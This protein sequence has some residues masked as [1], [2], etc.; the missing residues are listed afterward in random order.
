MSIA[1]GCYIALSGGLFFAPV[2]LKDLL[3]AAF[4]IISSA[5]L[6]RR[7]PFISGDE[8]IMKAALE[9]RPALKRQRYGLSIATFVRSMHDGPIVRPVIFRSFCADASTS[10]DIA[11]RRRI[12]SLFASSNRLLRIELPIVKRPRNQI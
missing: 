3:L 6:C 4:F 1:D 7:A 12:A 5:M 11:S 2:L 8:I 10:L 9:N